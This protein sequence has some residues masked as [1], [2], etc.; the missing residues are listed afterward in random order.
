MSIRIHAVALCVFAFLISASGCKKEEQ[1]ATPIAAGDKYQLVDPFKDVIA[2]LDGPHRVLYV[3]PEQRENVLKLLHAEQSG[4]KYMMEAA[5]NIHHKAVPIGFQV[6]E[7]SLNQLIN[8]GAY[9]DLSRIWIPYYNQSASKDTARGKLLDTLTRDGVFY[10]VYL[11]A[12][13]ANVVPGHY[14]D[15]EGEITLTDP[16]TFKT[17]RRRFYPINHC[18][19]GS[20]SCV[21]AL[22]VSMTT[23]YYNNDKCSG[24][25]TSVVE[26]SYDFSCP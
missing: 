17:V 23:E 13:C 16:P 14:T 7:A 11:N 19:K 12:V 26:S 1:P 25:P 21:E 2:C 8:V 3:L 5:M 20:G 24:A 22:G 9:F 15:C 10:R 18:L 4:D 6:V